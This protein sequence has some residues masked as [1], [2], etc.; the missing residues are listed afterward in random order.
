MRNRLLNKSE[1]YSLGMEMY[2]YFIASLMKYSIYLFIYI[3]YVWHQHIRTGK[4]SSSSIQETLVIIQL[5]TNECKIGR[6][7][8][9]SSSP[10]PCPSR[11]ISKTMSKQL[12]KVSEERDN[13]WWPH[14]QSLLVQQPQ[15]PVL[16]TAGYRWIPEDFYF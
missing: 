2:I 4:S 13:L 11:A 3:F 7:L 12:L 5:H 15:L 10:D 8:W 16:K 9:K 14:A 1:T 6:D